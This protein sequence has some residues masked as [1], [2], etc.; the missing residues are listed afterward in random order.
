MRATQAIIYTKNLLENVREA[1]KRAGENRKICVPVKADAYGHGALAVSRIVLEAGADILAVADTDEANELRNSGIAAPILLLSQIM[2]EEL[3]SAVSQELVP[4]VSDAAFIE[5]AAV[6]AKHLNKQLT[7]H[8]KVDSGLRRLGCRAEDAHLLAGKIAESRWLC[9]GGVATHLSVSDSLDPS[10]IAYTKEQLRVFCGAVENI[11]KAGVD[12]GIVHAA[13]S[14]AFLF[15]PDAYFDMVRPGIFIYGYLP[16]EVAI[17]GAELSVKPVMELQSKLA[18]IKKV[19]KGEAVSY[20]RTWVAAEDTFIGVIPAGYG[21][22][23]PR[24]LSN[25]HQ[26]LIRGKTYPIAGRICMDQCMVDLGREPDAQRWDEV[27]I[28]GPDFITAA[29][30]AKKTG[31]IPYEITCGINKRV[32]RI[33]LP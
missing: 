23:L 22:G 9:L 16:D 18:V 4:M 24:R 19:K 20:G 28:F 14:G 21:D 8:L 6:A 2:P 1:R 3:P 26:V 7:V 17:N 5:E 12:P 15:H 27:T 29:G 25:D 31:T 11:K 10:D 33:Y 13:N 32:P 30:V